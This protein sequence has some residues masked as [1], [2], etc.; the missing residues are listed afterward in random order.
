[1][2]L[3]RRLKR[4]SDKE[5][6]G[7][8]YTYDGAYSPRVKGLDKKKRQRMMRRELKRETRLDSKNN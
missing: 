1:M 2:T 4:H 7:Y 6:T 5:Y 3:N 8:D